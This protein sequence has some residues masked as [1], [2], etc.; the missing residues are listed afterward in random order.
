MKNEVR[1]MLEGMMAEKI[2]MDDYVA[3]DDFEFKGN[4]RK[5]KNRGDRRRAT[6]LAKKHRQELAEYAMDEIRENSG[7]VVDSGL[8]SYLKGDKAWSRKVRHQRFTDDREFFT[9]DIVDPFT[10]ELLAMKGEELHDV[11]FFDEETWEILNGLTNMELWLM[12]FDK[13]W[14]FEGFDFPNATIRSICPKFFDDFR[15]MRDEEL[16][17]LELQRA[18][19]MAKVHEIDRMIRGLIANN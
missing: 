4:G 11:Q 9:E 2:A 17:N 10:G 18:E 16:M 14:N 8:R 1:K 6:K 13:D 15:K 12:G 3:M 5:A 19:L 7:K